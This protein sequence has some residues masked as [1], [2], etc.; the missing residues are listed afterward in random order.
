MGTT[1]QQQLD[2]L[3][4]RALPDQNPGPCP[5]DAT[6]QARY[7]HLEATRLHLSQTLAADLALTMRMADDLLPLLALDDN[8]TSQ[9][10]FPL[11]AALG[12][13]PVLTHLID[14]ARTGS[15]PTRA[16]ACSA[17]YWVSVWR[18]TTRRDEIIATA[19]SGTLPV[20][21]ARTLLLQDQQHPNDH[22][23]D[24]WPHLWKAAAETFVH[25]QDDE[26]R[27]RLQTAFPLDADRYP[28]EHS[29]L[30]GQARLIAE[31]R[32]H[33][34]DRLLTHRTGYGIAI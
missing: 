4:D 1:L 28:P 18:P 32:S 11:I 14:H 8:L 21:Q 2:D 7:E 24:L 19:R 23:S 27:Q 17:A 26:L 25:C 29:P 3:L 34:F 31:D 9:L 22:I 12:R 33:L 30:L 20:E 15:W 10:A 16:G 5:A 13:R 6:P